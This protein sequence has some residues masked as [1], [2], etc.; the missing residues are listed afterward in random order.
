MSPDGSLVAALVD[1][2]GDNYSLIPI[3]A[4]TGKVGTARDLGNF[5]TALSSF[6]SNPPRLSSSETADPPGLWFGPDGATVWAYNNE[7]HVG[8]WVRHGARGPV[9]QIAKVRAI[10]ASLGGSTLL[11]LQTSTPDG[12]TIVLYSPS[13]VSPTYQ[14]WNGNE[15]GSS[16]TTSGVAPLQLCSSDACFLSISPDGSKMAVTSLSALQ[17][18]D[19]RSPAGTSSGIV[20]NRGG[21]ARGAS[22]VVGPNGN[23]ALSWSARVVVLINAVAHSQSRLAVPL[24]AAASIETVGF[25]PGGKHY[26]AIVGHGDACPCRAVIID[27]A[28]GAVQRVVDLAR[29][30][31]DRTAHETPVGVAL[32]DAADVVAV[33]F[34]NNPNDPSAAHRCGLVTYSVANGQ[35]LQVIENATLGLGD[36]TVSIPAFRPGTDDVALAARVASTSAAGGALLDARTGAILHTFSLRSGVV[37]VGGTNLANDRYALRFSA[38]GGLLAWNTSGSV[39][40]WDLASAS[41]ERNVVTDVVLTSFSFFD[42]TALAISDNGEVAT[43]GNLYYGDPRFDGTE[44]VLTGDELGR[45]LQ[46]LGLAR[47]YPASAATLEG[48]ISVAM[49]SSGNIV[50]VAI[51]FNASRFFV[52]SFGAPPAT[53]L[54]QLCTASSRVLSSGEWQTYFPGETYEPACSLDQH[55]TNSWDIDENLRIASLSFASAVGRVVRASQPVHPQHSEVLRGGTLPDVVAGKRVAAGKLERSSKG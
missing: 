22:V 42:P 49:P 40:I 2:G 19:L 26:V 30:S 10:P 34:D 54:T 53:L 52:D 13:G 23:T 50:S 36:R 15:S 20:A 48:P 37:T 24:D 16:W 27:A 5:A 29:S 14:V 46:P 55:A 3:D 38:N 28:T 35:P 43:V 12:R 1:R 25:D 8:V 39:V 45:F 47:I 9:A 32:N 21:V 4:A 7:R 44:V 17:I 33:T 51:D 18:V 6:W 11:N 31:L 41:A